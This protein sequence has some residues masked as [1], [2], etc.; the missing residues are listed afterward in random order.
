MHINMDEDE[1]RTLEIVSVGL[2]LLEDIQANTSIVIDIRMKHLHFKCNLLSSKEPRTND[3]SMWVT[4]W[5]YGLHM[6]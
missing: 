6:E 1:Q 3:T 4:T 2:L 5:S